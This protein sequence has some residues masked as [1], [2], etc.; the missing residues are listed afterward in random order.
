MKEEQITKSILKYLV[1]LGWTV[2]SYDFPQS[3]T[4]TIIQPT[5]RDKRTKNKGAIIPDII[6]IRSQKVV[7][8]ENKDHFVFSDFQKIDSLR[9]D[10]VYLESFTKVLK[11]YTYEGLYYGVGLPDSDKAK[12]NTEKNKFMIDFALFVNLDGTISCYDP[13]SLFI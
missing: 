13:G 1:T 4:G 8:F 9:T 6:A 5:H 11:A 2:I 12:L 3:G 7:I 10:N